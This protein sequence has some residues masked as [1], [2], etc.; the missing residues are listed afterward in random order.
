VDL[1]SVFAGV[2]A[3]EHA[4]RVLVL[5]AIVLVIYVPGGV[6]LAMIISGG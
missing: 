6:T 1:R 2:G 3:R 5:A 4:R